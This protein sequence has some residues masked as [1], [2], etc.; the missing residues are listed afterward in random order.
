MAMK[1]GYLTSIRVKAHRN[2]HCDQEKLCL[3]LIPTLPIGSML[4]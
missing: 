3:C 1:Q 2:Y 4:R